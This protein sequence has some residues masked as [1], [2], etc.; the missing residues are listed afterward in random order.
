MHANVSLSLI[1][2]M[3]A[4]PSWPLAESRLVAGGYPPDQGCV[5]GLLFFKFLI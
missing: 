3:A 1:V 2:A 5:A 4:N